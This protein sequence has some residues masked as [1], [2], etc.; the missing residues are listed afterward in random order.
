[1]HAPARLDALTGLRILAAAAVFLSHNESGDFVPAEFRTFMASGYNGVT[2]F[3]ILSGFVLAWNYADRMVPMRVGNVWSFLVARFARVY[4]LYLLAL[5]IVIAPRIL[6]GRWEPLMGLHLL[7][8]QTWSSS[9]ER[10]FAYNGPGWSIGVEVCLYACFPL[11]ILAFVKIA[12]N[13]KALLIVGSAIVGAAFVIVWWFYVTG[14]A[15]LPTADPESAHRWLYRNP[16]FRLGDFT[17]GIIVA[18]LARSYRPPISLAVAAQLV[19]AA[20]IVAAMF[21]TPFYR[22]AWSWDAIYMVPTALLIWGLATAPNSGLARP[23]ST[24]PMIVMGEASFAFYLLHVPLMRQWAIGFDSLGSWILATTILF[25][26]T[27]FA[28]I[29]AHIAVE[30]PAQKWLRRTLSPRQRPDLT[31]DIPVTSPPRTGGE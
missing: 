16:A 13:P 1:M 12:R 18:M 29:G 27:L 20:S 31:H 8:L 24:R 22:S 30:R 23:L 4:P 21:F 26:V 28:A 5:L 11:L 3:F 19:G 14:R 6:G 25:A 15:D 7:T 2:L 10:A 9:K 17:I